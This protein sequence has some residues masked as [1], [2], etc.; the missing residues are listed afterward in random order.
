MLKINDFKTK[1]EL[2]KYAKNVRSELDMQ[3]ISSKIVDNIKNQPFFEKAENILIFYPFNSEPNLLGLM[4]STG[5]NWFLPRV[6][7]KNQI[8]TIHPFQSNLNLVKNKWGVPEPS[9]DNKITD[10][11]IIDLV[12]VPALMADRSG[13]RLGY[14]AGFYDRF[15]P[16][17]SKSCVKFIP[18]P[19]E[20]FV[21]CLPCDVWDIQV[22]WV[23]TESGTAGVI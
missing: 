10:H 9:E 5:K 20:L 11:A 4:V 14:G 8:L 13:H 23:I 22:D 2:R 16:S 15:L 3:F 12:A 21:D 19:D 1:H 7:L 6:D 17:L 18:V